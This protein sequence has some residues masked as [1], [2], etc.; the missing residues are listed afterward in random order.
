MHWLSPPAAM[1]L[2]LARQIGTQILMAVHWLLFA[3]VSLDNYS[4][5]WIANLQCSTIR[6]F[7]ISVITATYIETLRNVFLLLQLLNWLQGYCNQSNIS[8]T[9]QLLKKHY[10]T[11]MNRR[12]KWHFL[13]GLAAISA[14]THYV[15]SSSFTR[16][17]SPSLSAT[18]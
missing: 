17:P 12:N 15:W 5:G 11:E 6:S 2:K 16:P 9:I 7:A 10:V 18:L 3:S 4:C 13:T 14:F 8:Q 1:S